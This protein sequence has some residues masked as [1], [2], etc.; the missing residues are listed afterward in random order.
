MSTTLTIG[1]T[2][3]RDIVGRGILSGIQ[4]Y[5]LSI[6]FFVGMVGKLI[7]IGN[8]GE[9]KGNWFKEQIDRIVG[10]ACLSAAIVTIKK[11]K[12]HL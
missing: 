3:G 10:C 12:Y 1:S 5:G 11:I 4:G 6:I 2:R 8:V 7:E 9:Y